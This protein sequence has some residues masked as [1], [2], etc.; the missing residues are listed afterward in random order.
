VDETKFL[1][2]LDLISDRAREFVQV[3][4]QVLQGER[5]LQACD[6]VDPDEW[7]VCAIISAFINYL[8][9]SERLRY[10]HFAFDLER[11]NNE[12]KRQIAITTLARMKMFWEHLETD[13]LD[14]ERIATRFDIIDRFIANDEAIR[15]HL[16]TQPDMY[17]PDVPQEEHRDWSLRLRLL[18]ETEAHLLREWQR[19][20]DPTHECPV[21]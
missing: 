16:R 6:G 20:N 1:G 15:Q 8:G 5:A 7:Q 9:E 3:S 10:G 2:V 17:Q 14:D 4:D 13:D 12:H 11:K 19:V 18:G 21:G